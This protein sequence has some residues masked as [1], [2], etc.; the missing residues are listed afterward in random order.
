MSLDNAA[1]AQQEVELELSDRRA[2][3]EGRLRCRAQCQQTTSSIS[4]WVTLTN[5]SGATIA[6]PDLH[7]W[8]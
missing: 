7:W 3:M 5:T 6:T 8:G 2:G 4:G 1:A